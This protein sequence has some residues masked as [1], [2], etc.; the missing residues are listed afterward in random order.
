MKLKDEIIK[1][2]DDI[3]KEGENIKQSPHATYQQKTYDFFDG[4]TSTTN[5]P[6]TYQYSDTAKTSAFCFRGISLLKNISDANHNYDDYY[7]EF[8]RYSEKPNM[9]DSINRCIG[10]LS[11]LQKDLESKSFYSLT[12]KIISTVLNDFLDN[13]KDFLEDKN[14]EY[15]G[16]SMRFALEQHL[17]KLAEKNGISYRKSNGKAML[18]NALNDL[19]MKS[20]VYQTDDHK[21]ISAWLTI[22]NECSHPSENRPSIKKLENALNGVREFMDR[23]SIY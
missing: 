23:V 1:E 18:S 11:A 3:I 7:T 6:I 19:L 20:Q 17:R 9:V 15:A 14:I 21:L 12:G 16:F 4:V 8:K 10:I 2:L 22:C 5:V 13:A